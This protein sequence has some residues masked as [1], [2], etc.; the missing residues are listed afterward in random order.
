MSIKQ[1]L[2]FSHIILY[3]FSVGVGWGLDKAAKKA[4]IGP[5]IA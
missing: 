4:K 2:S 5:M 1:D 3:S